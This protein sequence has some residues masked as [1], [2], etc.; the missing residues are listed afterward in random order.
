M[1]GKGI[2]RPVPGSD[3]RPLWEKLFW[4]LVLAAVFHI[5]Y[6]YPMLPD[7]VA[8]HFDAYGRPNGWAGKGVFISIYAA[9]VVFFAVIQ[10][11]TMVSLPKTP[12]SLINLP[13]RDYWL[14][15]ERRAESM[16]I[17]TKYMSGFWSATLFFLMGTM[18]LAI[19]A[20]LGR[21]HGLGEWFFFLLAVY[22]LFTIAWSA[23]LIRRFARRPP[24]ASGLE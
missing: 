14:S 19:R 5:L 17:L 20:N 7:R 21:S 13:N 2:R 11:I 16:E 3:G 18:H 4:F 12:V 15:P 8:S 1:D 9:V 6:Y 10:T 24:A 22:I 23:S